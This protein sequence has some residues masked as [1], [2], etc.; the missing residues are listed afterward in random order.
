MESHTTPSRSEELQGGP[1]RALRRDG[2][3]QLPG[4]GPK[5]RVVV[6]LVALRARAK[7]RFFEHQ[8]FIICTCILILHIHI[9]VYVYIYVCIYIYM[10][11]YMMYMDRI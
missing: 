3:T 1:G 4:G 8:R 6:A 10:Y 9:Y 7:H 5:G 11:M 2:A